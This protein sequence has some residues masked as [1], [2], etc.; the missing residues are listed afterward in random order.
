MINK[1][2][3]LDEL[4]ICLQLV[5]LTYPEL[6]D[7]TYSQ[8]KDVIEIEFDQTV[9]ERD[10]FLLYEPTIEEEQTDIEHHYGIMYQNL[11]RDIY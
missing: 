1:K 8:L 5:L 11:E 10:V 9:D 3:E 4:E 7:A 2:M 6:K